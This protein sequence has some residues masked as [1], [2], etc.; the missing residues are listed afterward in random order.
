ASA[1]FSERIR[2][3]TTVPFRYSKLGYAALNVTNL[4]KSVEFYRDI[5][6]LDVVE[7]TQDVA[8]L[9]CSRDHHNV[10]LYQAAQSGLKRV[11]FE[12]ESAA[13]VEAAF[14]HFE[15]NGYAPQRLSEVERK[16]LGFGGG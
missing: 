6:G 12:L 3:M 15:A 2:S 13:D 14:A 1:S 7:Q 10:V 4:A 9:R 16:F 8:F 11:G 5:V